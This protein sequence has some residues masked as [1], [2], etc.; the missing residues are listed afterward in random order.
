MK[1]K[2]GYSNDKTVLDLR[3]LSLD[4][5]KLAG[6]LRHQVYVVNSRGFFRVKIN[7]KPKTWKTRPH[8]VRVPCKYGLYEYFY[9]GTTSD[10]SMVNL[11]VEN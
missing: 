7:G 3:P 8:S 2:S 4:E 1:V 6:S 10:C 9:A 5:M 11:Y